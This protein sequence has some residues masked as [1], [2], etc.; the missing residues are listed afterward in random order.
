MSFPL[1]AA[2]L[3]G[4]HPEQVDALM[5]RVKK[6][7]DN[8]SADLV[9]ARMLAVVKFDLVPGGYQISA[10]DSAI[11]RVADTFEEREIQKEI[12]RVGRGR[13]ATELAA[14]LRDLKQVLEADPKAVFS[15][16]PGGYSPK[17]VNALLR[18]IIIKRSSLMAPDPYE[19]RT[20][21]LGRS[22]SGYDRGQVD[23]LLATVVTALHQQ[24]ILG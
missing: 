18:R 1:T 9:T 24:R 10:V 17:L 14:S 19:L 22:G 7:F 11:A 20:I 12:Q 3:Q 15:K 16:A 21:S 4:Y 13:I 5:S 8:P 6:Q 23:E 2:K